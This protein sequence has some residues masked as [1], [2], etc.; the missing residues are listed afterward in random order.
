MSNIMKLIDDYANCCQADGAHDLIDDHETTV[1]AHIAVVEAVE[2]LE[3]DAARYRWLRDD[4]RPVYARQQFGEVTDYNMKWQIKTYL[5]A[6]TAVASDVSFNEAIDAA[7]E[8]T[9]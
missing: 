7:M 4:V 3:K 6:V 8:A 2:K 1:A 5:T 9:K